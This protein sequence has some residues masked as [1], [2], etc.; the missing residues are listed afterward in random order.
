M[1]VSVARLKQARGGLCLGGFG[2]H[3]EGGGLFALVRFAIP[4]DA[5]TGCGGSRCVDELRH[6]FRGVT[7]R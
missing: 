5:L 6:I 2:I 3:G 1:Q 7:V 4:G